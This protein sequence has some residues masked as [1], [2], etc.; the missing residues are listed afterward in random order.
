MGSLTYDISMLPYLRP[1]T[2]AGTPSLLSHN[3]GSVFASGCNAGCGFR[4]KVTSLRDGPATVCQTSLPDDSE[5]G[6][7][8]HNVSR[9]RQGDRFRQW[10]E[11]TGSCVVRR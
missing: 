6:F 5:M 4:D 3:Q 2:T 9:M 10:L 7:G 1:P 11:C 8:R